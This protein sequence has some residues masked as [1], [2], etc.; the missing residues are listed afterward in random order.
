VAPSRFI[1]VLCVL[2]TGC[3]RVFDLV[4]PQDRTCASDFLDYTGG[5]THHVLQGPGDGSFSYDP[6]AA[7]IDRIEGAYDLQTG[8]FGWE[9][10]YGSGYKRSERIRDG[11][12]TIWRDGDLDLAYG[13][14]TVRRDEQSLT[15]AVRS[16]RLGCVE[17]T[18]F[19]E[20]ERGEVTLESR[21]YGDSG[22]EITGVR[23]YR[24]VLVDVAGEGL[25]DG[26]VETRVAHQ[27]G[28]FDLSYVQTD[29]G[30][31][32]IRREFD[33]AI[34]NETLVGFWETGP[35]GTLF[36]YTRQPSGQA[37]EAWRVSVDSAG[38]GQGTVVY[39]MPEDA[40]CSL[41]FEAGSC[42]R[43]DCTDGTNGPCLP[44]VALDLR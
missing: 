30:D 5:L 21:V 7:H 23:L 17:D 31:G 28:P 8:L 25:R 40:S 9:V 38:D 2:C 10:D 15:Y 18:R 16:I 20:V 12:G 22:F 33:D 6:P 14:E 42:W 32:R 35:T 26:A 37:V 13:L 1:G 39:G 4:K 11:I 24:G 36:E 29:D 43:E 27:D 34:G 19:E 41:V 44:P 3:V